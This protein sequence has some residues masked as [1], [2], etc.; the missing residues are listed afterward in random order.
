MFSLIVCY[1]SALHTV[2]NVF[3]K[4]YTNAS[5]LCTVLNVLCM[6]VL[7]VSAS[8]TVLTLFRYSFGQCFECV[9]LD[10]LSS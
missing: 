2:L 7:Y 9:V 3:C 5:V 1:V 4:I 8:C 6:I 10:C